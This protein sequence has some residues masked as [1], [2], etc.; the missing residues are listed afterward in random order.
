MR[1]ELN[2]PLGQGPRRPPRSTRWR[3]AAVWGGRA[4]AAALAVA[5][6]AITWRAATPPPAEVA[7]LSAEAVATVIATPAATATPAPAAATVYPPAADGGVSIVRNG[8]PGLPSGH[9]PQVIDVAQAL[10]R[11]PGPALNAALIEASKYGPLPRVGANGARPAEAYAR[12]FSETPLTRGAP[13]VAV[14]VGGVGLDARM[15]EAA[16]SRLPGGVSLGFA[17]YGADLAHAAAQARGA[18]HEIWLQAPMQGVSGADPGPHT[19]TI[20]ASEGQNQDSLRWLM[21]RF[22][23]YVGIENY[24]GAKF[25]ADTSALSPT[26]AEIARR[27]LLYLDDGSSAVSK[28]ADLAPGLD[29]KAGRADVVADGGPE[30]I[31][32]A[33]AQAEDI[34][35]RRGSVILVATALP[36]TLDRI[37]PWAQGLADK[38]F[39]LTPVSTLVTAKPNRAADSR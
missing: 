7:T 5:V 21:S 25:T 34:A 36:A 38:G 8:G 20:A 19:L 24:L 32:A 35:R 23:G 33:M 16:I 29:L 4:A 22:A 27:G 3:P 31:D 12:P 2:Q 1:D 37:A 39:V 13:R 9:S 18:G 30:A 28:V 15:T 10:G 14:L 26:L 6:A 11:Q 17:P